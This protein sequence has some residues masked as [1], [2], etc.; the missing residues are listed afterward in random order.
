VHDVNDSG[1]AI[2]QWDASGNVE[3]LEPLDRIG[4]YSFASAYAISATGAVAG[5]SGK[6]VG[7][8]LNIR[9]MV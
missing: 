9:P 8:S 2:G 7:S 6:Q 5:A 4:N 1:M 3:V